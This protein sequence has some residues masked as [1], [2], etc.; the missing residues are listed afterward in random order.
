MSV[1][2]LDGAALEEDGVGECG[3][4]GVGAVGMTGV[5]ESIDTHLGLHGGSCAEVLF[6]T[7]VGRLLKVSQDAFERSDV[8]VPRV[9]HVFAVL[10]H[11]EGQVGAR[12]ADE[13]DAGGHSGAVPALLV[14]HDRR[15][16]GGGAVLLDKLDAR[17]HGRVDPC[18]WCRAC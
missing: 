7:V 6:E 14:D 12:P 11:D 8:R 1:T 4:H 17:G 3:L 18:R 5:V 10:A 15:L 13:V 9:V 2:N 16:L